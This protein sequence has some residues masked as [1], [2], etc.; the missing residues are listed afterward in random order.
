MVVMG[1]FVRIRFA[2]FIG[3]RR[4]VVRRVGIHVPRV[5]QLLHGLVQAQPVAQLADELRFIAIAL[6]VPFLLRLSLSFL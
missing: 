1:P 4:D 6:F 5:E 3:S 2:L